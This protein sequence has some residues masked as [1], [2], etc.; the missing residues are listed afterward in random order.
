MTAVEGVFLS[1]KGDIYIIS[2]RQILRLMRIIG[3]GNCGY[4]AILAGL[5]GDQE[6]HL[7]LR[8]EACASVSNIK[9]IL[10]EGPIGVEKGNDYEFLD[11]I[12]FMDMM[13]TPHVWIEHNALKVIAVTLNLNIHVVYV[14]NMLGKVAMVHGR[15]D[16]AMP[17][18]IAYNGNHYDA[19]VPQKKITFE[20]L[21]SRVSVITDCA[22]TDLYRIYDWR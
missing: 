4:R 5:T 6:R 2:N 9:A 19:F 10:G 17:V 18:Y 8:Q 1:T 21:M 12:A 11:P 22:Q 16:K 13:R 7:Q 3:D 20:D 14:N 15:D